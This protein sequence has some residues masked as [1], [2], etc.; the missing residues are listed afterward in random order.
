[1]NN[2]PNPAREGIERTKQ[3]P[4]GMMGG[5]A[6]GGGRD[7]VSPTHEVNAHNKNIDKREEALKR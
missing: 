6:A 7:G 1:M 4:G 3:T 2:K 5:V